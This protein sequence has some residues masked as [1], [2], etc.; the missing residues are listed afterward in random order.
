MSKRILLIGAGLST[1]HLIEYLAEQ[2]KKHNWTIT[3]ADNNETLAKSKAVF[4]NTNAI[5]L[6]IND[7]EKTEDLISNHNIVISM[8]PPAL[9]INVAKICLKKNKNLLTA[10]Y[11]TDEMKALDSEIKQKG[12][13]FLNEI[14][15]D[16]GIDH[17]TAM[18]IINRLKAEGY[19][20]R[21]F[22]SFTGG[23]VAPE[24]D[25]NP[26]H[27]KFTWN[28]RNVVLAG[29]GGAVKFLQEGQIKYIPY[30]KIFRRTEVIEIDNYGKFE[31]YA[32][33]DSLK[34]I[35]TYGLHDIKTMFRGTLRR[36]GFCKAWDVFVSLGATDDS[37]IIENSENMTYREFINTFLAYH[38][39]DSVEIK[40][41]YYLHIDQDD[42]ELWDRLEWL[43]IF[44]PI[45]IGI[46]N[47]TPAQILQSILEKKW[48]ISY[49]EKDMI[50][51]WHKFVY[52]KNE[53]RNELHSSV[54]V[55][56]ENMLHTSMSKTVGLP[57]GIATKLILQDK[58]KSRGALIPILPEFYLPIINELKNYGVNCIEKQII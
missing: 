31:G 23:L 4:T 42:Q 56:G 46:K 57:L 47:A 17:L 38:P 37:Y 44:K 49:E 30:H 10:S 27:Y 50:V 1:T 9:H 3:I 2:G 19:Y 54:V 7:F 15:L 20:I 29:Q 35:N 41:K 52:Y 55:K 33:R 32:N 24:N 45:K 34:Y 48:S 5:K 39:T 21:E 40:L 26:W 13:I 53:I 6:D 43:D 12:L 18:S 8:L 51:M 58:I 14:G 28:P 16:P 36:P 25:D 22:E 11:L